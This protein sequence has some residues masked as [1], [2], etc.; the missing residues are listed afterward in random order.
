M[1]LLT[2]VNDVQNRIG[3]PRMSTVVNN[4]NQTVR[5]LLSFAQQEGFALMQRHAWEG[6]TAEHVFTTTAADAQAGALPADFDRPLDGSLFNRST[7]RKIFGP[8]SPQEWQFRKSFLEAGTIHDWYRLR[9]GEL[10]I[11]PQPGGGETVAYEYVSR[12]WVEAADGT[13]RDRFVM[14]DDCTRFPNEEML[15]AGIRWRWLKAKGMEWQTAFQ[16]YNTVVGN[17]FGQHAGAPTLKMAG[18]TGA[19]WSPNVPETGYGS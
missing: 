15:S 6:L 4:E 2:A 19:F 7:N 18:R 10:L 17:S 12:N 14:D 8:L 11:T 1:S 16:E 5:E 13:R 3:L 9:G